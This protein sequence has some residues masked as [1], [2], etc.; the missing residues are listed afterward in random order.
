MTISRRIAL[1]AAVSSV[2]CAGVGAALVADGELVLAQGSSGAAAVTPLLSARRAPEWL[3]R[4]VAARRLRA[5]VAPALAGLP[6]NRCVVVDDGATEL[7]A[8]N[9]DVLLTPASNLKLL[10]ATAAIKSLGA[11]TRLQTRAVASSGRDAA[12]VIGGDLFL[13][14]G[15]DPLL[16][17]A[18]YGTTQKYGPAPHTPLEDLADRIRDAGV[19]RVDG[20][21]VGDESR[22]DGERSVPTWPRRLLAQNQVGPLSALSVNDARAYPA[23]GEAGGTVRPAADPAAYAAG[24]LTELLRARGVVVAG[25][26][27]SGATPADAVDIVT[28]PSLTVTEIVGEMLTYSDNNTAELLLKELGVQKAGAGTTASGLSVERT[29]LG[30]ASINL[31][32]AV[33]VDGSGL[34]PTNKVTCRLLT[35]VLEADGPAGPVSSG[36]AR[37]GR[38][39]TLRDRFRQSRVAE[40]VRAKTGTLRGASALS[41]WLT[42]E[43]GSELAFSII[44]DVD[45]RE[46]SESDRVAQERVVEA[47]ASYPDAP[48]PSALEPRSGG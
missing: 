31:G 7:I 17:T 36:L 24:A 33:V 4:P 13:V 1:L 37:A 26:P 32:T 22:Y 15:G 28:L 2:V 34:D 5:A 47:L 8:E 11:D 44:S 45:G 25:E 19:T 20:A 48:P 27:R 10:V 42:T 23:T 12:G 3:A 14:G 21:V 46:V 38:P 18:P 30:S 39:G 9:P 29:A 43:A 35:G 40:S 41:G 16:E 6:A